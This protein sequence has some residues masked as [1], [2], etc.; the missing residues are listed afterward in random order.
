MLHSDVLFSLQVFCLKSHVTNAVNFNNLNKILLKNI[1]LQFTCVNKFFSRKRS[2]I[3]QF[4]K[5][6]AILEPQHLWNSSSK[7]AYSFFTKIIQNTAT[8]GPAYDETLS[9]LKLLKK[10]SSLQNHFDLKHFFQGY[11]GEK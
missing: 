4:H 10:M 9:F 11:W 2:N 7:W 1:W 3:M 8:G 6:W 5:F